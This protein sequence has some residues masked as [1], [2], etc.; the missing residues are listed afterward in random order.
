MKKFQ[1][2]TFLRIMGLSAIALAVILG[3]CAKPVAKVE[4]PPVFF[5]PAPDPPRVQFLKTLNGSDDLGGK[6]ESTFSLVVTGAS[7][8]DKKTWI[9]KPFG[10]TTHKGKI[11]VC[12]LAGWIVVFD[13]AK[14]NVEALDQSKLPGILMPSNLAFDKDDNLY[15]SDLKHKAI[16]V[17]GP[18]GRFLQSI[19]QAPDFKPSDLT[20]D[21]D[22]VY[23]LNMAENEIRIF[24]RRTGKVTGAI[25]EGLEG[26]RFAQPI[27][28]AMKDGIIYVTNLTGKVIKV[29]R[30]GNFL[31]AFGE[32]GDS[33]ATFVRPKGI[34]IDGEDRI[35]V[36]D[37]GMQVVKIFNNENRLLLQFGYPGLVQGSLNLPIGIAVTKDNISYFQKFADP[38][39]EVEYL[40]FVINQFGV[41]K[42]SVYGLGQR[43]GLK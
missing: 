32:M 34:A 39:F 2:S 36:V 13:P 12:D 11:Y 7:E 31:G 38:S 19:G 22:S 25:G 42:L 26:D 27:G 15:V 29:D 21:G 6:K 18:D 8:A 3:G 5:P 43:R 14:E 23:A 41:S 24:D 28:L 33:Y 16:L 37:N 20:V 40:I 4:T 1:K 17:Y 30:D 9:R 10:V 35:F